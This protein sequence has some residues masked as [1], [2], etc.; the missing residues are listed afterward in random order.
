MTAAV[1]L[2][3]A[4]MHVLLL[5]QWMINTAEVENYVGVGKISG[6]ELAMNMF[7]HTRV[8]EVPFDYRTVVAVE[9]GQ[10]MHRVV[11]EED[12]AVYE[13]Q[14]V[15]LATGTVPRRLGVPGEDAWAGSGISWCAVC[16]G[17]QYPEQ[18]CGGYWRR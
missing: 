5:D 10:P 9:K 3:R 11:C 4:N 6:A 2:K 15:I 8:L 16:D 18:G 7:E 17:A 1:Y 14:A 12:N 13:A